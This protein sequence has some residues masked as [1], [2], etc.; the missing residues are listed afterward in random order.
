MKHDIRK[1]TTTQ[2]TLSSTA[3]W[4]V[5]FDTLDYEA[6]SQFVMNKVFN[7][8][9]WTDI[10]EVLR[11]YGLDRVRHETVR[12]AYLKNTAISFLCVVLGLAETDFVAYQRR[13]NIKPIWTD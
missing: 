5:A 3:F 11:F 9:L 1:Q 10:I 8:G 6:D 7:Y 4:D 2:P 12:A 13:Q